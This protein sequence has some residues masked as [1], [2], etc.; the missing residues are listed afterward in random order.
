MITRCSR[1][2]TAALRVAAA[3]SSVTTVWVIRA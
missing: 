2:R 1:L 3:L